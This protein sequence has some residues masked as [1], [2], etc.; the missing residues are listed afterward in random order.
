LTDAESKGA[1][2]INLTA[3]QE[4]DQATR[5][6]PPYLVLNTSDEME[7]MQRE[8][9]GP[10]LP[11]LPYRDR[12]EV[13]DYVNR[14]GRPLALYPFTNDHELRDYYLDHIMSGGVCVNDVLLQFAQHDM[15]FGGVGASGMGQYHAW[16]GFMTFSKMRP[17]FHQARFSALKIL[18]PLHGKWA[19][20][21]LRLMLQVKK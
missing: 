15:P 21:V 9:F 17:V 20:R 13:T 12:R 16:E 8:I 3:E 18:T 4:P 2:L 7:L 6:L 1:Q 11:V 19:S 10:I 14:R 5:K